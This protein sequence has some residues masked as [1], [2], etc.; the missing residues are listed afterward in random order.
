M[1]NAALERSG[2]GRYLASLTRE[3][4]W[5]RY[6]AAARGLWFVHIDQKDRC[7]IFH[8]RSL[9]RPVVVARSLV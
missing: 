9:L 8:G 6:R 5:A 1:S 4:A 2:V 7:A 3:N